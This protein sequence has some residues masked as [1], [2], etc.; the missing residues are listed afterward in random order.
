MPHGQSRRTKV[1]S[2]RLDLDLWE[3]EERRR[4]ASGKHDSV[5][6]RIKDRIIYDLTRD[7]R[8]KPKT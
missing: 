2:F 7:K 6:L 1:V 3:A 8:G 5:D 4:K